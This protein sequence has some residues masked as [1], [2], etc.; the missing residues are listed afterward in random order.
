MTARS[1]H[2]GRENGTAHNS[3]K[4][5]ATDIL[6]RCVNCSTI[7]KGITALRTAARSGNSEVVKLLLTAGA[8]TDIPDKV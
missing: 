5:F 6:K 2:S 1:Y 7:Q 4:P 3:Q 8:S